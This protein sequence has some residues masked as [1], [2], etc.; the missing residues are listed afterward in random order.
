M[1]TSRMSV[2]FSFTSPTSF[3]L[4]SSSA[5]FYSASVANANLV[6]LKFAISNQQKAM[7]TK[8]IVL[9]IMMANTSYAQTTDSFKAERVQKSA[10]F[11]VNTT[12]EKAFPLF[13]PIREKEW[14]AGWEPQVIYA[15]N[16]EVEKHMIF[17]TTANHHDE[18][19]YLRVI[20]QYIPNDYFIEYTVST[21]QRLWFISVRC[22]PKGKSTSVTVT[23]NYTGLTEQGNQLNKAA[24]DKMFA[25]D[26]KDW[27]EA[28]N[29]YLA[30]GKRKED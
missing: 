30:T 6:L 15:I 17:K 22:R 7:K 10:S 24:L 2:S 19:E 9:I 14:A 21:A 3:V 16:Q 4:F 20:T 26:L 1:P 27:E 11:V 5:T 8:L 28:I 25:H 29:Y 23:Y 12:I 18:S 13:G